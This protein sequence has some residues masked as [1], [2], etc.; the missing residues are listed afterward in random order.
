MKDNINQNEKK[1]RMIQEKE[2]LKREMKEFK[3]ELEIKE[4]SFQK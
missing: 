1:S 4:K 3:K 2:D